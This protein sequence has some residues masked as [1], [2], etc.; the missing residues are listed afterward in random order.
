VER[1]Q[2]NIPTQRREDNITFQTLIR[3]WGKWEEVERRQ[4]YA[5]NSKRRCEGDVKKWREDKRIFQLYEEI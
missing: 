3:G 5:S 4:E 2:E 1:R